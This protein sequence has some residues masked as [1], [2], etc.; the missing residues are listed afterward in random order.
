MAG[1]EV[2]MICIVEKDL[3]NYL[4][5]VERDRIQ[6]CC[7]ECIKWRTQ[8]CTEYQEH[9]RIPHDCEWCDDFDGGL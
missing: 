3:R 9:K 7:G 6:E 4:A 5:Q 8:R 2:I 1:G